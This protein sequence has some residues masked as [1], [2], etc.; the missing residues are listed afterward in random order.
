MKIWKTMT[1][2]LLHNTNERLKMNSFKKSRLISEQSLISEPDPKKF[3]DIE[4]FTVP[5]S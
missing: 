2:L 1:C 4:F 3:Q 5:N